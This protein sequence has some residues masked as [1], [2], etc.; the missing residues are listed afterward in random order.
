MITKNLQRK[1]KNAGLVFS[2]AFGF[3]VLSAVSA[4]AQY[5]PQNQRQDR[6]DDRRERQ[7]ERRDD[8]RNNNR[9]NNNYYGNNNYYNTARQEGYSDGLA[10]GRNDARDGE[11]YNPQKHSDYKRARDGYSGNSGNKGQYKQTYRAAFLEGYAQGY[12]RNNNGYGNGRR[13]NGF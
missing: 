13:R 2:L 6:R 12:N 3:L 7:R 11:R 1:L 9:N 4:Q 8:Y 10:A 5:Y